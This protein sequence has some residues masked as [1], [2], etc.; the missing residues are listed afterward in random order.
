MLNA[1]IT[2]VQRAAKVWDESA[3]DLVTAVEITG[4]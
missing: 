1:A 3:T 2:V 4:T